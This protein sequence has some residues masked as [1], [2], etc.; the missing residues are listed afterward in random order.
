LKTRP[1]QLLGLS[2]SAEVLV[3]EMSRLFGAT[4]LRIMTFSIMT[5][6]IKGFFATL[7]IT[8]LCHNA[9]CGILFIVMLNVI[10]LSFV[11]LHVIMPH[12]I[13][14]H[15][16]MPHVIMLYVIMVSVVAPSIYS[17]CVVLRS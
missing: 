12:V 2:E 1:K 8:K 9:D 17:T 13:M 14:L 11:M 16:I 7:S 10:M 4:T 15:A 3:K 5:L 6:S